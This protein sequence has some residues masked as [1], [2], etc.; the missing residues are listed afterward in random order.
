MGTLTSFDTSFDNTFTRSLTAA[1]PVFEDVGGDGGSTVPGA[2]LP[3]SLD[4]SLMAGCLSGAGGQGWER[5]DGVPL[6]LPTFLLP[7]ILAVPMPD[8]IYA[9]PYCG[10]SFT[11]VDANSGAEVITPYGTTLNRVTDG[12]N[13]FILFNGGDLMGSDGVAGN[14]ANGVYRIVYGDAISEPFQVK[15]LP[16]LMYRIRLGND[17]RIGDLLYANFG[18]Q[19]LFFVEGDLSGPTYDESETRSGSEKTG[20]TVKKV[21]TLNLDNVTEGIADSLAMAGLHRLVEVSII[22]SVDSGARAIQ[23]MAYEAKSTIAVSDAGGFDVTLTLPVSSTSWSSASS[24]AAGCL[25]EGYGNQL[26]EVVCA[27]P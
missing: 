8:D 20:G 16:C 10:S 17:S 25:T 24:G 12:K 22:R 4:P 23:A 13:L 3:F 19:Q 7:F 9:S 5:W 15:C 2:A 6:T 26:T 14:L 11:I 27:E 1:D 21:W 18:F